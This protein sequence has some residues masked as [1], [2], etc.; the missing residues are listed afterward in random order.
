MHVAQ[1]KHRIEALSSV[2][3]LAALAAACDVSTVS[4]VADQVLIIKP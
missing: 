2:H 1:A 3:W 4:T